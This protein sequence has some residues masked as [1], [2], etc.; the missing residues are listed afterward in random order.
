M[1]EDGTIEFRCR[2]DI[3]EDMPKPVPANK[4]IPDWYEA[5]DFDS[6]APRED[7]TVKYCMSFFDALV[8]G[9]IV[10]MPYNIAVASEED[11]DGIAFE[12]EDEGLSL[13]S[14]PVEQLGGEDNPAM[15]RPILKFN[16][17]WFIDT[18]DGV[19]ILVTAPMNRY[20]PRFKPFSGVIDSDKGPFTINSIA[21]WTDMNYN[22]VIEKGTPLVQVIPYDRNGLV[23]DGKVIKMEQ[24][25]YEEKDLIRRGVI[26]RGGIYKNNYWVPKE[27]T[28]N[29]RQ[30]GPEG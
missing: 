22:G 12:A 27:G 3:Y 7:R 14:H 9:W 5:M 15:P 18:P 1:V 10:P 11:G 20:E 6:E 30:D 13:D 8:E 26:S 2:P 4:V 23:K 21:M 29:V 19:S 25:E 16:T 28:R 24:D 17:P